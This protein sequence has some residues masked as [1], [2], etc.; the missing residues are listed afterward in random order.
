MLQ[1]IFSVIGTSSH[2]RVWLRNV[3]EEG[4]GSGLDQ[5]CSGN[6][7]EAPSLIG[8]P[9]QTLTVTTSKPTSFPIASPSNAIYSRRPTTSQELESSRVSSAKNV[10]SSHSKG[11]TTAKVFLSVFAAIIFLAVIWY[12]YRVL[13]G[14][15]NAD[16]S[17]SSFWQPQSKVIYGK[18]AMESEHGIEAS[19]RDGLLSVSPVAKVL[20]GRMSANES[21]PDESK[22]SSDKA[23]STSGNKRSSVK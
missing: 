2:E 13:G 21:S 3:F 10:G 22:S 12:L 15:R 8:Q 4:I 17:K 5:I 14:Y 11:S 7:Y 6:P 20:G 18:A 1:D 23:P 16:F 19:S 9:C